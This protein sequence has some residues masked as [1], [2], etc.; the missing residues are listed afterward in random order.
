MTL[1][2]GII[3]C[4]AI[5]LAG[6]A[7][8]VAENPA[9]LPVRTGGGEM[10]SMT[11]PRAL[12][13]ATLLRDG[14]TLICGGTATANIGGVLSSAEIYDP[15]TQSFTLTGA[16]TAMRQGHTATLLPDGTVLLAG[17]SDNIGF[18]SELASAEIFD[19]TSGHFHATGSMNTAREGHTAT[20]LRDGRVLIAGG[21]PNGTSTT[22]SAEVYDYRTGRFTEVAPMGVPR[23][24]HSATL[25]RNGKV[26]IAGGGRGNMPGGYIAYD[27]AEI[28]D[29]A[30]NKFHA[31]AAHLTVDRIALAAALLDDGRVLLAGGK[32]GKIRGPFRGAN[33]SY[34]TP[35]ETAEVFDPE[36]SSFHAVGP[37]QTAHYLGIATKLNDGMVLITGGWTAT[38]GVVGGIRDAELFDPSRDIFSGGGDLHVARLNQTATLLPNGDVMVTG[39]LDRHGNITA[40]V[41]FYNPRRGE[42][43]L[44]P[45]TSPR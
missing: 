21:S 32:S 7:Q 13:S 33:L 30:N 6:C 3:L 36:T 39:G 16:M 10:S 20:L 14:K 23:E 2:T 43:V 29:P 37:M 17:G 12:H 4:I 28:F 40:T 19:P 1:R 24:A 18:R 44:A 27:T 22:S 42:F 35:L 45:S 11:T 38:G 34:F 25:L 5:M 26:L 9:P 41:E 15:A 31:L 8:P